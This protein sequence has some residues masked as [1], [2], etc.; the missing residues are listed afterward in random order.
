[1]DENRAREISKTCLKAGSICH[2]IKGDEPCEDCQEKAIT[3]A[4][5]SA[6][7]QGLADATEKAA[8]IMESRAKDWD[9]IQAAEAIRA[10]NGRE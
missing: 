2:H 8:K 7:Q 10:T 5:L 9:P 3:Q 4:L 1:M 6:Y